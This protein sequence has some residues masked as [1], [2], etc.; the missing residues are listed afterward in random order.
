MSRILI[1]EDDANLC[2]LYASEFADEGYE[3]ITAGRGDEAL[4]QIESGWP[5]LVVL[6]VKMEPMDGLEVLDELLKRNKSVPVVIN[7]AYPA[8]KSDF[9]TWGADAY[10]VKSAD[11]SELK[12]KVKALLASSGVVQ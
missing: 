4:R 11:L 2:L 3:V 9:S 6:D 5:D 7:S 12:S 1:V 10:V 8:F